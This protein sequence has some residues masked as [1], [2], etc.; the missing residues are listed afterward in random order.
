[1]SQTGVNMSERLLTLDAD[2]L[3]ELSDM[4]HQRVVEALEAGKVVFL[5]QYTFQAL[6]EVIFSEERVQSTKKNIS[7]HYLTQQLS[8]IPLDSNYAA[9]IAEMMGR[10]A[11]FAHQLVTKLCPHYKQGL[12]W[13][14]T[15]FRPAEIDGRKRS[16]RQD[17]TRLHVDSFPAT[18]VHGQRILR[19][20]CNM[21]PYGKP[22]V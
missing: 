3:E 18:P 6:D 9:T 16:K 14:R 13:G 5:P 21:N 2:Q 10:Y 4:P 7:Y 20:F 15:S 12:R 8:G 19:V 17:D 1:M 11:V 22:R